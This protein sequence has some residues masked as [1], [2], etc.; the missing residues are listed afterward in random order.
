[1]S[2]QIVQPPMLTKQEWCHRFGIL[3]WTELE[4]M[5]STPNDIIEYVAKRLNISDEESRLEMKR[6]IVGVGCL[7]EALPLLGQ[8]FPLLQVDQKMVRNIFCRLHLRDL[9]LIWVIR[10]FIAAH[11]IEPP[12]LA[13]P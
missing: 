4:K 5:G 8:F 3:I 12:E 9:K 10:F 2:E 7:E 13:T 1:M 6:M 11:M